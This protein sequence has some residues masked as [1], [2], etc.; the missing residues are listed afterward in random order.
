[1]KPDKKTASLG[2]TLLNNHGH[3]ARALS[4]CNRAA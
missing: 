1:M 2:S 4:S 3:Q